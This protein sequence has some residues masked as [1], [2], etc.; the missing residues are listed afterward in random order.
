M[1]V[2]PASST[3]PSFPQTTT[4]AAAAAPMS[5]KE[6][7]AALQEREQRDLA[8]AAGTLP[9]SPTP[10]SAALSNLALPAGQTPAA[11]RAKIAQF[12]SKGGVPV[13][14]GAFGLGAPPEGASAP[15]RK[16]L[17]GNRM[18]PA[19]IPRALPAPRALAP[20]APARLAPRRRRGPPSP[21]KK[22][23]T[24]PARGTAFST[25]L[26]IARKAEADV[27]A[28][29]ERRK[30]ALWLAPQF[31]GGLTPQ[32]TGALTPQFTGGLTPQ[33]TGGSLNTS[34]RLYPQSGTFSPPLSPYEPLSPGY[35]GRRSGEEL[36]PGRWSG[37]DE[38]VE[39]EGGEIVDEP[40][41]MHLDPRPLA[42]E[43]RLPPI[44][45]RPLQVPAFIAGAC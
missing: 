4:T 39:G 23:S 6:R 43:E 13:P 12:E 27:R 42:E 35:A 25:A 44:P 20:P 37:E 24:V 31:T 11:L 17:Y 33:Y 38:R 40:E 29:A 26:D 5:L 18:Q 8:R 3:Q 15:R 19:R 28:G 10:H 21:P 34:P 1:A 14:R 32:H 2:I 41:E 22:P 45:V 16:E 7:I 36:E 30:S 9:P